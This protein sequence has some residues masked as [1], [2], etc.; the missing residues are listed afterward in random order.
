MDEAIRELEVQRDNLVAELEEMR[1]AGDEG[2]EA[3][4]QD[5]EQAINELEQGLSDMRQEL[6]G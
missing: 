4:R 6:E 1:A 2:W 5:V 3:A